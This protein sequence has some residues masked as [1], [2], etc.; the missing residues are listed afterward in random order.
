MNQVRKIGGKRFTWWG[1]Y[2]RK[3]EAKIEA[4]KLRK[5]G[6]NARVSGKPN[7]YQV[8]WRKPNSV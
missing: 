2:W 8:F 4:E 3:G 7:H 1:S 5:K 6:Y